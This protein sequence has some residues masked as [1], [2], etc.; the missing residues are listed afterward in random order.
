MVTCDPHTKKISETDKR[1]IVPNTLA[2]IR[3]LIDYGKMISIVK[4]HPKYVVVLM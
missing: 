3:C 1:N 4:V 2:V